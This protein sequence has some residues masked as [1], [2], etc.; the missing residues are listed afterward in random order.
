MMDWL[1]LKVLTDVTIGMIIISVLIVLA[2]GLGF[3]FKATHRPPQGVIDAAHKE[4]PE[5]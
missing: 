1:D 2:I 3:Y 5:D 4:G